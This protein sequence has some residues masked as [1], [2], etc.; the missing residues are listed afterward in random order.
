MAQ[1]RNFRFPQRA[2]RATA[3]GVGPRAVATVINSMASIIW[4]TGIGIT[5]DAA[6][7]VRMRGSIV[8]TLQTVTAITDHM[9]I[10]VGIGIVTTQAFNAGAA[11]VPM[12]LAE[13]EWDGWMWHQYV[14]LQPVSA[15]EGGVDAVLSVVRLEIDSKAMRKMN[16]DERMYG[17][18]ETEETGTVAAT[19]AA[20]TRVL[21]KLV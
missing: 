6:T 18:L 7:I 1:P 16:N 9:R 4:S 20:D 8:L 3:W 12:P 21:V 11:S 15:V 14:H 2:R 10:G 13:Q 19:F 5:D 17:A